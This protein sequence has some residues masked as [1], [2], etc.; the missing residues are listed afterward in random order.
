METKKV[1]FTVFQESC[2]RT[3]NKD[4]SFRDQIGNAALGLNGEAGEAAEVI[5]KFLYQGHELDKEKAAKELGDTLFYLGL[6]AH[7]LGTSLE[8]I[9]TNN[10]YK[11]YSRYP[12][13]F[14]AEDSIKRVDTIKGEDKPAF[15]VDEETEF[16]PKKVVKPVDTVGNIKIVPVRTGGL[17][18]TSGHA[19]LPVDEMSQHRPD[20][21]I[22]WHKK[23]V[24]SAK[25]QSMPF[26]FPDELYKPMDEMT[27]KELDELDRLYEAGRDPER[28]GDEDT[29]CSLSNEEVDEF[30]RE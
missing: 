27:D 29:G 11:R 3:M 19:I 8:E 7:M 21:L 5:K 26:V 2:I 12:N 18:G 20:E 1:D 25:G 9:A 4:L 22:E 16:K 13:G 28:S 24:E 6:F 10:I 23:I 14:K 15:W 30:W 17:F